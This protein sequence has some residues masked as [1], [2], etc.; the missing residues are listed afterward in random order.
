MNGP[1]HQDANTEF[2]K[3]YR[4]STRLLEKWQVGGEPILIIGHGRSGTTWVGN[5]LSAARRV[6]YY[7]EPCHPT[8]SGQGGFDI[9]FRYIRPG[10]HDELFERIL[11]PV[12]RGLPAPSRRWNRVHWHRW[13]PGYRITLKEV[14]SLMA[15][16]WLY[17][18]YNPAVLVVV[19]HQCSVILSELRQGT[20]VDRSMQELFKQPTLFEDHLA[21]YRVMMESVSTP[22]EILAAIWGARHRVVANALLRHPEWRVTFYE[23]LCAD[24]EGEFKQLIRHFGLPWTNS[25]E[26]FVIEQSTS[27]VPGFYSAKRV[28]ASQIGRWKELLSEGQIGAIKR[29]IEAFGLPFYQSELDWML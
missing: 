28:S 9:W 18:R 17:E 16:E 4:M 3:N 13:L 19:R 14:A 6:L 1:G 27:H 5:I 15:V 25:M 8:V 24:P 20:P 10:E 29:V 26:Q 23:E 11:D 22:I 21:P 7:F 2:P 12:F